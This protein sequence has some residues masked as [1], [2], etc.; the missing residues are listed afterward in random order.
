MTAE[1][2]LKFK[3]SYE[4]LSSRTRTCLRRWVED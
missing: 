1:E 2:V 3:T 4:V